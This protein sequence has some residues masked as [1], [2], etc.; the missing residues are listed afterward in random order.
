MRGVVIFGIADVTIRSA[1]FYL[2]AAEHDSG[3]VDA[4]ARRVAG[5]G[6]GRS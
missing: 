5:P 4:H 3:D 6:Q 2:E 1:R